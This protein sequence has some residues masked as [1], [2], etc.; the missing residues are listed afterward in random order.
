MDSLGSHVKHR[1]FGKREP[2]KNMK[3]GFNRHVPASYTISLLSP[4]TKVASEGLTEARF[5]WAGSSAALFCDFWLVS[6]GGPLG[7]WR[8]EFARTND[9]KKW[10]WTSW[11]DAMQVED[12]PCMLRVL[13][14]RYASCGCACGRDLGRLQISGLSILERIFVQCLALE[15]FEID[16]HAARCL[17]VKATRRLVGNAYLT[18]HMRILFFHML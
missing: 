11:R 5:R 14:L 2:S 15:A 10:R 9:E 8:M 6:G 3:L 17:R 13:R 4:Y 7:L 12:C 1:C 16:G 18:R